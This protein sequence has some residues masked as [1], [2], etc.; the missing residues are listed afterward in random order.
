MEEHQITCPQCG[1]ENNILADACVQCGIIFVKDPAMKAAAA[2]LDDEKRKSIEAAEAILDETQPPPDVDTPKNE[3]IKRPDPHE[4]TAEIQIPKPEEIPPLEAE[5]SDSQ[6]PEAE[7]NTET[8]NAE[9][10]LEAIETSIETVTAPNETESPLSGDIPAVEPAKPAAWETAEKPAEISA[11]VPAGKQNQVSTG[12]KSPDSKAD[13]MAAKEPETGPMAADPSTASMLTL[14]P[15]QKSSTSKAPAKADNTAQKSL[16]TVDSDD[17]S[18]PKDKFQ[19][20]ELEIQLE[21]DAE[22]RPV[23]H[24]AE[25]IEAHADARASHESLDKKAEADAQAKLEAQETRREVLKKQ[26]EDL[27][28]AEAQK[29]EEAAQAKA[30]ALKKKKLARAKAEALKKQKA[31]QA[32]AETLKKKKAAQARALAIKKK[33]ADQ[34]KADALKK[35]KAAQA[36]AEESAEN[37]EVAAGQS[38]YVKLLGLLKRY[39]GKAIGINYDNS[40]EIKEAELVEANEEFFSVM[41]KEKEVQYSYPLKTI[42]TI[43]EGEQGVETGEEGKTAKFEAVI[44][45]YP[46]VLF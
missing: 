8:Q 3:T 5:S 37:V 45:V 4:D 11:D 21:A 14:E 42:L 23:E 43:V 38:N 20:D 15:E 28:K 31:A 22:L 1:L 46:L 16:E 32:K 18:A 2:A 41:V 13:D 30:A 27:L 12:D 39:K 35:Q 7:K 40:S 36:R 33:K 25:P 24:D 26:Q 44:K 17:K 19:P 10:E 6:A 34:S 9:I 29:K